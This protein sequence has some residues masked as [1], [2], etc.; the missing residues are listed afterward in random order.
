MVEGRNCWHSRLHLFKELDV[1]ID[2]AVGHSF[3][4]SGDPSNHLRHR[5]VRVYVEVTLIV[6][7]LFRNSLKGQ[8]RFVIHLRTTAQTKEDIREKILTSCDWSSWREPALSWPVWTS[9][10]GN[11]FRQDSETGILVGQ[12]GDR[13]S[14]GMIGSP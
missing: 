1:L 13:G 7:R 11:P 3:L 2:R 10:P 12:I 8:P 6:H 4:L 9:S 5:A 14:N